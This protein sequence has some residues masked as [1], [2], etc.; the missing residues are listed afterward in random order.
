[1]STRKVRRV[2]FVQRDGELAVDSAWAADTLS[3]FVRTALAS[4]DKAIT[5]TSVSGALFIVPRD[6]IKHITIEEVEV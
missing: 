3:Y 6:T 2:T 5:L 4:K 1:V